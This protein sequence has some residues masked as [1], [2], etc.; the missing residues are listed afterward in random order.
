[1]EESLSTIEEQL[2]NLENH[3]YKNKLAQKYWLLGSSI[4][5]ILVITIAI[6]FTQRFLR[7]TCKTCNK[8]KSYIKENQEEVKLQPL[9]ASNLANVEEIH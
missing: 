7:E 1:M 8:K 6:Y 4:L 2:L 5:T 9:S 3:H